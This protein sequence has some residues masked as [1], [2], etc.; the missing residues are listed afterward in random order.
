V[1]VVDANV[2]KRSKVIEKLVFK[3]NEPREVENATDWEKE[4][5]LKK[6]MVEIIQ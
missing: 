3:D 6:S 1:N 5:R 2:T 4:K